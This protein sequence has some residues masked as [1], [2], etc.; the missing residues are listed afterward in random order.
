MGLSAWTC[1]CWPGFEGTPSLPLY[2]FR[3]N[4]DVVVG[5]GT[6]GF[7]RA[8]PFC[9]HGSDASL[10]LWAR[11]SSLN[12]PVIHRLGIETFPVDETS[13]ISLRTLDAAL[14]E[15]IPMSALG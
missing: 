3:D 15:R 12:A 7:R 8:S 2:I 9:Q 14:V 6:V 4:I 5:G 13:N 11:E 1:T 10:S